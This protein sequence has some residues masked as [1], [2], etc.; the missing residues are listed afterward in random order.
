MVR[1]IKESCEP[2]YCLT[3]FT[4]NFDKFDSIVKQILR[5]DIMGLFSYLR[6]LS[7]PSITKFAVTLL[8]SLSSSST[9][10]GNE[11]GMH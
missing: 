8:Q 5:L 4:G 1:Y 7:S 10:F 6:Y 11:C 2:I 9:I 3:F